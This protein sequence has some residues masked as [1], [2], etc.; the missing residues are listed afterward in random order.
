MMKDLVSVLIPCYNHEQYI[1]QALESVI[2]ND[3]K[4]KEIIL[5]DDGSDDNSFEVASTYLATQKEFI[6]GYQCLKQKN[7]GVTKTL[8]KMIDL[9][10]GEYVTLLASDDAM[11]D[12]SISSRVAY[13]KV[14]PLKK[15]VIGK[16]Y[17]VDEKNHITDNN[18]AKKLFR[19]NS[20]MLLSNLIN[21]ELTMRWSAVGPTL[22][23]KK[24][25]YDDVGR[26]NEKLRVEDRDFYLRMIRKD[27]LGYVDAPVAYYRVHSGNTSRTRTM[28]QRAD[29]LLEI[30]NVNIQNSDF[31]YSWDEK[32]FLASY[33]IDKA[34]IKA[35]LFRLLF[36]WKASR[37]LLV[38]GY[39]FLVRKGNINER[40]T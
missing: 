10:K 17:I 28:A 4:F 1:V 6:Y 21:K 2:Q 19:A 36:V 14:N 8:N 32:L 39:L 40:N 30:C 18:A 38:E 27:L 37:G 20:K 7:S 11:T 12:H 5:I 35:K 9:A 29:L 33:R 34:L 3:Y 15:A 22:L 31:D 25:V 26:Y 13:L 24:E 16:A 23:L